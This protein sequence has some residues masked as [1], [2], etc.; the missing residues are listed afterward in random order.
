[1]GLIIISILVFDLK[2]F[3][4]TWI[5]RS[6]YGI[7]TFMLCWTIATTLVIN[8]Q[9][10]TVQHFWNRKILK[11]SCINANDFYF[12]VSPTSTIVLIAVLFLPVPIIWKLQGSKTKRLGLAL[13]FTIGALYVHSGCFDRNASTNAS[14]KC[15]C[16]RCHSLGHSPHRLQRLTMYSVRSSLLASPSSSPLV[17]GFEFQYYLIPISNCQPLCSCDYTSRAESS[18][19]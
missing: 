7:G 12:A 17:L 10:I 2:I 6:I 16:L 18:V 15:L 8:F 11:G 3:R 19:K 13:S 4:R 14:F 5:R 1:M 9:C